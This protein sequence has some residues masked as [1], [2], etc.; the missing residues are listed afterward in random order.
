VR[1]NIIH[2]D[3]DGGNKYQIAMKSI[4]KDEESRRSRIH[5]DLHPNYDFLDS[6]PGPDDILCSKPINESSPFDN[7]LEEI[8]RSLEIYSRHIVEICTT[9]LDRN[10]KDNLVSL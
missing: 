9:H 7:K 4:G 5:P 3:G 8:G 10:Y 6:F 2:Q 1:N